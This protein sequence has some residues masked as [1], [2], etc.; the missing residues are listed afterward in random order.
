M[1]QKRQQQRQ[2]ERYAEPRP[3]QMSPEEVG[4]AVEEA[5]RCAFC[6][7]PMDDD[8]M[9][10]SE[11]GGPRQGIRCPACGA[12]AFRHFC[13]ACGTPLTEEA[14]RQLERA[15]RDPKVRRVADVAQEVERL[16]VEIEALEREVSAPDESFLDNEAPLGDATR[17]ILEEYG[18]L[19]GDSDAPVP[20]A[21][22]PK[23]AARKADGESAAQRRERLREL[24]AKK[25]EK[26]QEMQRVLDDLIPDPADP[27]EIQRAFLTASKV[28]VMETVTRKETVKIGWVCNLCGF[29][30][31]Q[32]S[33]CARPELGGKWIL[34][35]REVSV[36]VLKDR[37]VYI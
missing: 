17:S 4:Q 11:C 9:F 25:L 35:Q 32:P 31:H 33:E 8:E 16:E 28:A 20:A 1:E 15:R 22:A 12:M 18:S 24:K 14:F 36:Q 13:G 21:T 19:F 23:P 10:C 7:E 2:R 27:P 29:T 37:T 34:E 5:R 6:G 3:R 26:L 30:H